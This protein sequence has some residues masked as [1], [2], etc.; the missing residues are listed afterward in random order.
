MLLR[1]KNV[2]LTVPPMALFM[3]LVSSGGPTNKLLPVSTIPTQPPL[4]PSAALSP[5]ASLKGFLKVMK[6]YGVG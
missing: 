6:M 2:S 4:H 5:R 3:A 1:K